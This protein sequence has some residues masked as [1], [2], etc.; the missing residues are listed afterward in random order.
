ME[1]VDV[2]ED[3]ALEAPR[4]LAIRPVDMLQTVLLIVS[5]EL[6]IVPAFKSAL[7]KELRLTT[8]I[9][10]CARAESVLTRTT[11][12]MHRSH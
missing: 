1:K 7:A 9:S 12:P 11:T 3:A 4:E 8:R 10:D 5:H 2:I 6:V